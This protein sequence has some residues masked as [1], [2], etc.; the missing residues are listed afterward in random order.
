MKRALPAAAVQRRTRQQPA[1]VHGL[2][3]L[4]VCV[5]T[6]TYEDEPV[7]LDAKA[8]ESHGAVFGGYLNLVFP[9]LEDVRFVAAD[10]EGGDKVHPYSLEWCE[11]LENIVAEIRQR[12][13]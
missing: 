12:S 6:R 3:E 1:H 10:P 11:A 5:F 2:K 4:T 8:K 13:N 7:P 9:Q